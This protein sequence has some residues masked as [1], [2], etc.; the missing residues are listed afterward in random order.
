MTYGEVQNVTFP[1]ARDRS[2][3]ALWL[4]LKAVQFILGLPAAT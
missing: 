1:Q 3:I 4:V 2:Q